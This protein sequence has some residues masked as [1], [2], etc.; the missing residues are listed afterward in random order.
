MGCIYSKLLSS[1]CGLITR[2]KAKVITSVCFLLAQ[3]FFSHAA[4]LNVD[5][6]LQVVQAC[7]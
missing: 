2:A 5:Q 7:M 1:Y 6:S 3:D 4:T